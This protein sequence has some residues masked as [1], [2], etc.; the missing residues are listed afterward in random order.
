MAPVEQKLFRCAED[1]PD[2]CQ[3]DGT[4]G[5]GQ[6]RFL[7][8]RGIIRQGLS[9]IYGTDPAEA[10]TNCPKHKGEAQQKA[11]E[12][13]RVHDY[14]AGKW[15]EQLSKHTDSQ[16][17]LTLYGEIGILR[18]M[19]ENLLQQCESEQD[20]IMY[21]TR[22]ADL[23]VKLD[24]LVSSCDRLE[25]KR[26]LSLDKPTAIIF[27][28]NIVEII[29]EYVEPEQLDELTDKIFQAL[30]DTIEGK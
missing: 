23:A 7:S 5:Q 15:Q 25:S 26:K 3:A 1:D 12:K 6:C 13:R 21:S 30:S 20:L 24:K 28:S 17:L 9:E 16:N 27:A 4:G 8:V 22:A 29:T 2:R 14:A 18:L 19:L 10:A 11:A